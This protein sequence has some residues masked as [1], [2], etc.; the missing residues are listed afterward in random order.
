M[1]GLAS[2]AKGWAREHL[3]APWVTVRGRPTGRRIALTFDDGPHPQVTPQVLD[4]LDEFG[5]R[6]TFF[7]LGRHLQDHRELALQMRQRGHELANH[8][9]THAELAQIDAAAIAREFDEVFAMRDEAGNPLVVQDFLRP[10]KGVINL[11][12]LRYCAKRGSR[13]IHWSRDPE[14]FAQHSAQAVAGQFDRQPLQAGD[15][16][17][18]HDK[19]AHSAESL[20]MLLLRAGQLGLQCVRVSD[21]LEPAGAAPGQR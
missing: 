13:I 8:S 12:V 21:L 6:A 14:D 1:S 5:A 18:L 7:C 16:V 20:R 3:L 10:P 19:M 2:R 15:I 17:L 9:M 4:V 11:R